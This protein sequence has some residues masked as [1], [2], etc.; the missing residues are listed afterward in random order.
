MVRKRFLRYIKDYY[1]RKAVE[2]H[3]NKQANTFAELDDAFY[4]KYYSYSFIRFRGKVSG[5]VGVST[6]KNVKGKT[7]YIIME[8]DSEKIVIT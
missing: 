4:L 6:K 7:E 2:V 5:F 1:F 3:D 8:R